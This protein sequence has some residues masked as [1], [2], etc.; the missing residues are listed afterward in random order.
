M[1]MWLKTWKANMGFAIVLMTSPPRRE[2]CFSRHRYWHSDEWCN[3]GSSGILNNAMRV[4]EMEQLLIGCGLL[5]MPL[6]SRSENYMRC[7]SM[8]YLNQRS[9]AFRLK[10]SSTGFRGQVKS[11]HKYRYHPQDSDVYHLH[12]H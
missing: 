12:W 10:T 11:E 2:K 1:S 9:Y 7:E 6:A 4:V 3:K 5:Y 8:W